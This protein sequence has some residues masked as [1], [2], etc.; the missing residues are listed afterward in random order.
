MKKIFKRE[1]M[2]LSLIPM[3]AGLGLLLLW[4]LNKFCVSL[5]DVQALQRQGRAQLEDNCYTMGWLILL[6]IIVFAMCGC[7]NQF[8]DYR[9]ERLRQRE[10]E[11]LKREARKRE[12]R[13]MRDI[14][15]DETWAEMLRRVVYYKIK[16][17]KREVPIHKKEIEEAWQILKELDLE[18]LEDLA[19]IL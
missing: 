1:W 11:R 19:S 15:F 10:I 13:L 8:K 7:I 17:K 18:D 14:A 4:V 2:Y 16:Y 9:D 5:T 12:Q 6:G 3:I